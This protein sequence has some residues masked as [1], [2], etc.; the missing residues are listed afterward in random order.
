MLFVRLT[1]FQTPHTAQHMRKMYARLTQRDNKRRRR[2]WEYRIQRTRASAR[3]STQ[4]KRCTEFGTIQQCGPRI[5]NIEQAP[6]AHTHTHWTSACIYLL[7]LQCKRSARLWAMSRNDECVMITLMWF[8][9]HYLF[10]LTTYFDAAQHRIRWLLV[11]LGE[12]GCPWPSAHVVAARFAR[13]RRAVAWRIRD[14]GRYVYG[15]H[16]RIWVT[17]MDGAL[18]W[19]ASVYVEYS[20]LLLLL[21]VSL[22]RRL[23]VREIR[24]AECGETK[25]DVVFGFR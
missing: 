25:I 5:E 17:R 18:L 20:C 13:R 4:R 6:F 11:A 23:Y 1:T 19:W 2:R 8:G 15:A 16:A 7:T 21:L 12:R 3:H 14:W 24:R 22:F 9:F 10:R